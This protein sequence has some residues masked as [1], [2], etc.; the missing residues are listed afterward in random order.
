M[1]EIQIL[2]NKKLLYIKLRKN[3]ASAQHQDITNKK[4]IK[5]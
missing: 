5:F 1:N 3:K 2:R 4:S